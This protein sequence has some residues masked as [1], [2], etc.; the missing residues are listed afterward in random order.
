MNE[1]KMTSEPGARV[2]PLPR[3]HRLFRRA[4]ARGDASGAGLPCTMGSIVIESI[5]EERTGD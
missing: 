1:I 4:D 5:V 2:T 3:R